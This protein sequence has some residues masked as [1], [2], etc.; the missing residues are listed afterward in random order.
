MGLVVRA[1]PAEVVGDSSVSAPAEPAPVRL[2]TGL[3][4]PIGIGS[5]PFALHRLY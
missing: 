1:V 3:V 5:L 2:W 4:P